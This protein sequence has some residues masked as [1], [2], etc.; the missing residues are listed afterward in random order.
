MPIFLDF[1]SVLCSLSAPGHAELKNFAAVTFKTTAIFSI[2]SKH[3]LTGTVYID[4]C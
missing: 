2:L 1:Y 4:C 3:R